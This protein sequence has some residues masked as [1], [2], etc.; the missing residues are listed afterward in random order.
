MK[1]LKKVLALL[2]A[3]VM[4]VSC[5]AGCSNDKEP[6]PTKPS[7]SQNNSDPST[8]PSSDDTTEPSAV[9]LETD[10]DYYNAVLGGYYEAYQKALE[11]QDVSER[12]ALEAIAEAKLLESGIFMPTTSNGGNYAIGRLAPKSLSTVLWGNDCYRYHNAIVTTEPIKAAD[13]DELKALWATSADGAAYDKAAKELLTSKGYTIKNVYN[14][15]YTGDPQTWDV[16]ATY[17]QT[18]SEPIVQTY[19]GLVEYD[20]RNMI[21]PALAESWT[22]NED[23]TVFTFKIRQGATWVDSQGR[24]VADVTAKDW[25][26]GMQHMMDSQGGLEYLIDGV[27]VNAH[28]YMAGTVTD[29]AE[30]GVKALDDY[31]LEYTL[32]EPCTYF[33]TMLGYGVFA[34][35]NEEFFLS[36]GGVLGAAEFEAAKDSETYTYG[37]GPDKIAYCGP[38]V[39][40][41]FTALNSI[42]FKANETYWNKDN[43]NITELN[44][45]YNDGTD[46]SKSY[47]DMKAGVLDGAGLNKSTIVTAKSDT[48]YPFDE[49]AYV[50]ETDATAFNMFVNV[51]RGH[52]ANFN[53]ETI[54]QSIQDDAMKERTAKAVL[55]EHFRKALTYS[56]DRAAVNA[57]RVG[58]DL[59]TNNLINSYTPG[60]FVTL[61]HDVTIAINGTDTTFPAGTS[62]GAIVQAQ[63]DADGSHIKAFDPTADGGA[64]SSAGFDGWYNPEA[65]AEELA[66]AIEE[67]AAQGIEISAENPIHLD[68][69]VA[70][71]SETGKNQ[72]QVYKQSIETALKG[73]VIIDTVA[74]ASQEDYL[75]S[76]YSPSAG[77]DMNYDLNTNTGWGP[78]YGDPKTYLDTM[79]PTP[80][81]MCKSI[82]LF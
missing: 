7:D 79:L 23:N 82:G 27:I 62:Y 52:W 38:F 3:L 59:K 15:V 48:Q 9:E 29:M 30:V 71:Y 21:Q 53:D 81:G 45:L 55:N 80:G 32:T 17:Q 28:E 26:T 78:D 56:V 37:T 40:T 18:D 34:P 69:A 54:G 64:G 4:V 13:R 22:V 43:Q 2:L 6:D 72:G 68:L 8:E 77:A 10:E 50:S 5:F 73:C 39:I 16:L 1:N 61:E 75:A 46:V 36:Q 25:V 74:F 42:T 12:F 35:L 47:N 14:Y 44:W 63:L 20:Q 19:D 76:T 70:D 67:L 24:K 11:S 33:M 51:K 49:Y 60:T 65:A 58:D 41:N 57:Q 66:L 31:T